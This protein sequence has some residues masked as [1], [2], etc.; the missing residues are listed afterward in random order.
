M[1]IRR[2]LW[3]AAVLQ[4]VLATAAAASEG[5]E[6]SLFAGDLGNAVWTLVIFLLVVVVLGKFAWGPLLSGLQEREQF[7]RESLEKA[8][9]EREAS[10]SRLAEYEKKLNEARGEASEI[11]DEG[12]RDAEV[13]K[14][15]IEEQAREEA[16]QIVARAKREIELAK[17][18]AISE[19]YTASAQFATAAAAKI[20]GREINPEDHQ[21]LIEQ[22]IR[23][24]EDLDAN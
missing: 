10:E 16:S 15:R 9:E 23:E 21:R 17:K 14:G 11:V 18:T 4:A 1:L 7:I 5:G 22:S 24:I 6:S 2:A 12:R 8:K 20:I 3:S 19:I 13:V